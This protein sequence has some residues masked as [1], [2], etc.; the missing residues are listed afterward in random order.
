MFFNTELDDAS[1]L[2]DVHHTTL[3]GYAVDAR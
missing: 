2:T 1:A 3:T